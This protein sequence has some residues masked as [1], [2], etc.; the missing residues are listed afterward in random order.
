VN[1]DQAALAHYAA[2]RLA[3]RV[4]HLRDRL[5]MLI[6]GA[7]S[8]VEDVRCRITE[9]VELVFQLIKPVIGASGNRRAR[10]RSRPRRKE[11][12][13]PE[14]DANPGNQCYENAIDIRVIFSEAHI[15]V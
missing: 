7:F 8:L 14:T 5:L 10:L 4:R 15:P 3:G 6:D 2:V 1:T 11:D 9:L 12:P 13:Q